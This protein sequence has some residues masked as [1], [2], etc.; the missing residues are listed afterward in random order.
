MIAVYFSKQA[1][2]IS[3]EA[4]FTGYQKMDNYQSNDFATHTLKSEVSHN[5]DL[6]P[7]IPLSKRITKCIFLEKM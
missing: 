2:V 5:T 6:C 4:I 3:V 1:S 7:I